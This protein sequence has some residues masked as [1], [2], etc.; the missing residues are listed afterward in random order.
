MSSL[1]IPS[2]RPFLFHITWIQHR[3]GGQCPQTNNKV[4]TKKMKQL[5]NQS[6]LLAWHPQ[7]G[8]IHWRFPPTFSSK[9]ICSSRPHHH[10]C[11]WSNRIPQCIYSWLRPCVTTIGANE[12]ENGFSFQRPSLKVPLQAASWAQPGSSLALISRDSVFSLNLT[13]ILQP[14]LNP[15][16]RSFSQTRSCAEFN[17]S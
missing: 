15:I 7:V 5:I 13:A 16:S 4:S 8:S 17:A 12:F 14:P 11:Q 1:A 2:Q 3:L 10:P 9:D 6:P